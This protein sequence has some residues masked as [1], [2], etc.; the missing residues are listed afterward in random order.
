MLIVALLTL[1]SIN[2]NPAGVITSTQTSTMTGGYTFTNTSISTLT[3]FANV[4]KSSAR[5]VFSRV[6]ATISADPCSYGEW[7]SFHANKTEVLSVSFVSSEPV[8]VYLVTFE[9][10]MDLMGVSSCVPGSALFF[11]NNVTSYQLNMEIPYSSD[12]ILLFVNRSLKPVTLNL[13]TFE[14][15]TVT[16]HPGMVTLYS[17]SYQPFMTNTVQLVTGTFTTQQPEEDQHNSI[18]IMTIILAGLA[19]AGIAGYFSLKRKWTSSYSYSS[20]A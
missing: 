20:Q 16:V 4:T 19:M 18:I 17:T 12:F 9:Q 1:I 8:D 11:M 7:G 10:F 6:T 15:S 13:L 14:L 3:A 5:T 2:S